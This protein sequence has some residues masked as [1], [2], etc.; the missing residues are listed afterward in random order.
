M[1]HKSKHIEAF[2]EGIE[3]ALHWTPVGFL[4]VPLW[5]FRKNRS[6]LWFYGSSISVGVTTALLVTLILLLIL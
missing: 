3:E 5:G 2:F 6:L 1:K 4:T